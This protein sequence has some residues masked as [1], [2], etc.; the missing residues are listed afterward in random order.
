VLLSPKAAAAIWRVHG[1]QRAPQIE[2]CWTGMLLLLALLLLLLP[3]LL[4]S[5]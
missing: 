4:P 3:A 5:S 2:R 1:L